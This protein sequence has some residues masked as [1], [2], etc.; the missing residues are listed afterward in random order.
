LVFICNFTFK[1][2][3]SRYNAVSKL[4]RYFLLLRARRVFFWYHMLF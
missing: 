2:L 1:S 4:K 3:T